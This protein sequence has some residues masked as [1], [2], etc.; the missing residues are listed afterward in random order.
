MPEITRIDIDG[1]GSAV[2]VGGVRVRYSARYSAL[3]TFLVQRGLRFREEVEI[4]DADS[5]EF[6][7]QS[8]KFLGRDVIR[9]SDREIAVPRELA[10][11]TVAGGGRY[12]ARVSLRP[13]GLPVRDV[14]LSS[15]VSSGV[16]GSD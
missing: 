8:V 3:E 7:T 4:V 1:T 10:A 9:E 5:G 12:R 16:S 15:D 2:T 6:V 14:E 11:F 13:L